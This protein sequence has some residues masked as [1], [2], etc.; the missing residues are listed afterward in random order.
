MGTNARGYTGLPGIGSLISWSASVTQVKGFSMYH[1]I[2]IV[3]HYVFVA[4]DHYVCV[5]GGGGGGLYNISEEHT[6]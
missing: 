6:S 3:C 2:G 4:C 1:L 5:C